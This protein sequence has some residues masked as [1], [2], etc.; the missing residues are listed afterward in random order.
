MVVE[1]AQVVVVLP[2]VQSGEN[3][4]SCELWQILQEEQSNAL[5]KP[6][7]EI[8]KNISREINRC[9]GCQS[10]TLYTTHVNPIQEVLR[11]EAAFE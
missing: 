3:T 8:L 6:Q 1:L 7:S 4:A 10:P 5:I 2:V 9:Q 11:C